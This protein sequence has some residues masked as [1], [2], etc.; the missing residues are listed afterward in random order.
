MPNFFKVRLPH[1]N[2]LTK[3]PRVTIVSLLLATC[4]MSS[5]A[6]QAQDGVKDER[7]EDWFQVDLIIFSR[8]EVNSPMA[9]K[10]PKNVA[11]AYPPNLQLLIDRESLKAKPQANEED[12]T[13]AGL[14]G[15]DAEM[16]QDL[17]SMA[18]DLSGFDPSLE[19]PFVMLHSND[20]ILNA[21]ALTIKRNRGKRVLFHE[22][23]RQPMLSKEASPAI[24][25][26][27][28]E[29]FDKN[30]E[31]EGTVSIWLSRY[32]HISTNLWYTSFEPNYGQETEHWP[33][34]PLQP[35]PF[36][37]TD[38]GLDTDDSS[39][40]LN[41][42]PNDWNL[43]L[44]SGQNNEFNFSADV[45]QDLLNDYSNITQQPYVVNRVVT[46]SQKRRMRSSELHY[47]DHPLLG[48]LIQIER[49]EPLVKE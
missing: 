25:I 37:L 6:A 34:P 38:T 44:D 36:A 22:S 35:Q 12:L 33:Y 46:M 48:I 4:W 17:N 2:H 49:Y 8:A 39:N 9:E 45:T 40:V 16:T 26:K 14:E 24:V 10:W 3:L 1:L 15:S 21:E 29:M 28:G 41:R 13:E 23:W 18:V 43:S 7:Y 20:R 5:N 11:L 30:N 19:T 31:L 47:I 32:L 42:D 27:G